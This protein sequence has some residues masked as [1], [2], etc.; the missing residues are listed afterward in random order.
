MIN[1]N[2]MLVLPRSR[3][4]HD[5]ISGILDRMTISTEFLQVRTSDSLENY[6]KLY[7]Q[8]MVRVHA[9]FITNILDR[10]TQ[11]TTLFLMLFQKG[12]CSYVKLSTAFHPLANG[13]SECTF[14]T[15]EDMF[16]ACVVYFKCNWDDD[17]HLIEFGYNNSY[18]CSIQMNPYE[19][20][21]VRR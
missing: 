12:L 3:T 11:F 20:L 13:Q 14:Q 6:V 9:I 18:H 1:I 17:V 4:Q 15:L 21:Y 19:V 10:D 5:S 7:L 16:M 2:F 8:E